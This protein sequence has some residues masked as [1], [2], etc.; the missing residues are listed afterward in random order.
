MSRGNSFLMLICTVILVPP[1]EECMYRGLIFRNLYSR[2]KV[3]AYIISIALFAM[4]HI[5]GYLNMG[6]P[7]LLSLCFAQYVIPALCLCF[8][9][10]MTGSVFSPI[11]MHMAYNAI[12]IL[13]VR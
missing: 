3:L 12:G 13:F 11:L 10:G 1:F 9:Y 2:N 5:L 8:L 7:M 4:I 6:D